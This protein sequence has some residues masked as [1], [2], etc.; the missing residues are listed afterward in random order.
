MRAIT[1]SEFKRWQC[2]PALSDEKNR[3]Q[4]V[5]EP[6]RMDCKRPTRK[7]KGCREQMPLHS[8]KNRGGENRI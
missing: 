4:S 6:A 5:R 2:L 3:T 1:K 7:S 8:V